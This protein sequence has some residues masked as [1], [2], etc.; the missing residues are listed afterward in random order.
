VGSLYFYIPSTTTFKTT[1]QD[2]DRVSV[3]TNPVVLDA[4][5]EAVIFGDG[6]YRQIVKDVFGNTIWDALTLQFVTVGGDLS[7]QLPNPTVNPTVFLSQFSTNK[8]P[9]VD[10]DRFLSLDSANALSPI[11]F[12]W[13]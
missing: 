3:N 1:W 10:N 11:Y 6:E 4:N 5:G 8:N 13:S 2:P 9:P 7:G 12:L